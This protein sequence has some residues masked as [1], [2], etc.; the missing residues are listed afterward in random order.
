MSAETPQL[1]ATVFFSLLSLVVL[2]ACGGDSGS[3]GNPLAVPSSAN[4]TSGWGVYEVQCEGCHGADGTGNGISSRN[5]TAITAY[6]EETGT[7]YTFDSLMAKINDTMPKGS[8][9]FCEG[10]CAEDAAA[11]ILCDF[12]PTVTDGC[13]KTDIAIVVPAAAEARREPETRS[14]VGSEVP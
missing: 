1:R 14:G 13:D 7:G 9:A 4:L 8:P 5:L 10:E 3:S 11:M 2:T 6:D 12:N